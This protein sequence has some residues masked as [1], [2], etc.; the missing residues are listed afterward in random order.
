MRITLEFDEE[1]SWILVSALG[2]AWA[3][4]MKQGDVPHVADH[5]LELQERVREAQD[6]AYELAHTGKHT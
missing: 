5:I 3:D 6:A 2:R 4:A 1:Q